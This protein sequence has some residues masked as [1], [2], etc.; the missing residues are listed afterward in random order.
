[1]RV[2]GQRWEF[3]IGNNQLIVENASHWSGYSQER[4]RLNDAIISKR[5]GW[6]W[7]VISKTILAEF[8]LLDVPHAVVVGVSVNAT[9]TD[10]FIYARVITEDHVYEPETM[11]EARWDTKTYLWPPDPSIFP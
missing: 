4:V 2:K 5:E 11:T 1:M 7:V 3:R 9:K 8:D 10:A 6:G